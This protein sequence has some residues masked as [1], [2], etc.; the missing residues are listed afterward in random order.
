MSPALPRGVFLGVG[1]AGAFLATALGAALGAAFLAALAGAA[2]FLAGILGTPDLNLK[3]AVLY[4]IGP[5][6]ASAPRGGPIQGR[7]TG[8]GACQPGARCSAT[9]VVKMPPR[10]L[11]S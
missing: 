9:T 5:G 11:N 3:R 2:F 6:A 7:V 1:L 10:T 8:A 4:R